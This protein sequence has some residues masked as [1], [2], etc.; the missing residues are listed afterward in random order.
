MCTVDVSQKIVVPVKFISQASSRF[1][2][3]SESRGQGVS[4]GRG[5]AQVALLHFGKKCFAG[6]S[7]GN[8]EALDACRPL[9]CLSR[10]RFEA[11]G[12]VV[13]ENTP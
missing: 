1:P 11:C 9:R 13:L 7:P 4:S 8:A 3:R 5:G 2:G 10:F 6:T 12:I